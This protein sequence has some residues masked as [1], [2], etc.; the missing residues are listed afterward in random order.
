MAGLGDSF[1]E[2]LLKFWVYKDKTD[3]KTLDV[4]LKAME[5]IRN[6]L[7]GTSG[8]YTFLGE[9][10]NGGLQPKMGHLACFSGGL[11]ALSAMQSDI[12]SS[13]REGTF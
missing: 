7:V 6:K 13:D 9:Y 10:S 5:A 4:Y 12:P 1:Y 8:G 3:A 11:F 2:Y